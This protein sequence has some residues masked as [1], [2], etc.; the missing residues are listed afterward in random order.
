[1]R[2]QCDRCGQF[3]K[4][5]DHLRTIKMKEFGFDEYGGIREIPVTYFLCYGC[6]AKVREFIRGGIKNENIERCTGQKS[7]K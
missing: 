4:V 7:S 1:M 3:K 6:Y 5:G 2:G